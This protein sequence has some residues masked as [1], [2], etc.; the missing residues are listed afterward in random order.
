MRKH[1]EKK[2]KVPLIQ[3]TM[4]VWML[5][6]LLGASAISGGAITGFVLYQGEVTATVVEP[7]EVHYL[8]MDD[9]TDACPLSDWEYTGVLAGNLDFG[10]VRP[11]QTVAICLHTANNNGEDLEAGVVVEDGTWTEQTLTTN[12]SDYIVPAGGAI[13]IKWRGNAPA[14]EG[15]ASLN[16]YV[17]REN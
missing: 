5:A 3:K 2:V 14:D 1:L 9:G 17:F 11:N 8:L 16:L 15:S 13:S 4:P 10:N 12:T 7:F 6:L